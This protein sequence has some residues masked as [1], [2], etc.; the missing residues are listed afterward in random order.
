MTIVV[1]ASVVVSIV[2]AEANSDAARALVAGEAVV[3]PALVLAEVGNALWRKVRLRMMEADKARRATARLPDICTG[4][5]PLD[6]LLP[7]TLDLALRRDHP[8]YDCF[9]VAL[10]MH[11]AAPLVTADRHIADRRIAERFRNDAE[12]RLLV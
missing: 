9:Y 4:L 12:V 11:E 7:A 3:A 6:A 10:A 2:A 5:F 8:D 1:D